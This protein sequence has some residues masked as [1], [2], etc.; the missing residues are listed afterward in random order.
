MSILGGLLTKKK[1]QSVINVLDYFLIPKT[2]VISKDKIDPVLKKYSLTS[3]SQLPRI[4][5]SD[6]LVV[7]TGALLGDVLKLSREDE[8]GK[9]VYYRVVV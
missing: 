8:T 5:S 9:Y 3:S 1:Q 2:E 6:P 4:K 7:S